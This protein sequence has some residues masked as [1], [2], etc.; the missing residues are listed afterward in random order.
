MSDNFI[1][2]E[3]LS[4]NPVTPDNLQTILC[5]EQKS[6]SFP[7]SLDSF[8]N[9]IINPSGFNRILFYNH[10]VIGYFFSYVTC[11]EMYITNL[12]IAP[13]Y[14]NYHLG[15]YFL[16]SIFNEA[17]KNEVTTIF[18]EVREKNISA[19]KLY[20]KFNFVTDCIRTNFYS[21]GDSAILMH[22]DF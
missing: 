5:I 1:S 19:V 10:I 15:T 12:C 14:R 9:E 3:N 4:I 18:L 7:W 11:K 20:R 2:I 13:D 16:N 21:D 22:L 6:Y 17:K 8:K